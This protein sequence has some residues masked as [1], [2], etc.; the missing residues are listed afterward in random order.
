[1]KTEVASVLILIFLTLTFIQSVYDKL[2][3]WKP[4]IK[5]LEAHFEKTYLK[6]YI[7]QCLVI[8]VVFEFFSGIFSCVGAIELLLNKGTTYGYY[9]SLLSAIT[10]LF[11]LYGQRVAKDY[12]GSRTIV[13]YFIP[14]VLAVYWL[15]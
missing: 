14:C 12:D 4:T 5:G 7:K 1:M 9:G 11:M 13:L 2:F 10:L 6:K 8:L 3:D 15:G